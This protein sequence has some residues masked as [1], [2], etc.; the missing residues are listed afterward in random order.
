MVIDV[1]KESFKVYI[2]NFNMF[3][4]IN[5]IG[6]VIMYFTINFTKLGQVFNIVELTIIINII[7]IVIS[8]FG[9]YY[10]TRIN[11]TLILAIKSSYSEKR[12]G[13][14]EIFINAKEFTWGYI[15]LVLLSG[16]IISIPMI[17]LI[18][19]YSKVEILPFKVAIMIISIIIILYLIVIYGFA[20]FT[21][22][23]RPEINNC[24]AYSKNLVKNNFWKVL[25]VLIILILVQSPIYILSIIVDESKLGGIGGFI[26]ANLGLLF[27]LLIGPFTYGLTVISYLMLDKE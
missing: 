23:L 5:A 20:P 14:K 12:V 8:L 9:M 22:I 7:G 19:G 6:V 17:I 21:R 13:I 24:F 3:F 15:G 11:I 27:N 1:V 16:L 26:F 18:F 2:E 25:I 10:N 4:G